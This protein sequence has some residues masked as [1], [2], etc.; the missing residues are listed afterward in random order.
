[1]REEVDEKI[2]HMEGGAAQ[3]QGEDKLEPENV[4][5]AVRNALVISETTIQKEIEDVDKALNEE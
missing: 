4:L 2:S 5:D 1:M 3:A